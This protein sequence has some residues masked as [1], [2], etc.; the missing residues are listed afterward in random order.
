MNRLII[1]IK[2]NIFI[3]KADIKLKLQIRMIFIKL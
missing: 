3:V 1:S 2:N